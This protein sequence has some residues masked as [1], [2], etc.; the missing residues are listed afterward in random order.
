MLIAAVFV[1]VFEFG[2]QSILQRCFGEAL[3][4][5]ELLLKHVVEPGKQSG[6]TEE[7]SWPH[8]AEIILESLDIS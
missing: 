5:A 6:N 4:F 2:T 3:Q 7:D 8:N 1:E